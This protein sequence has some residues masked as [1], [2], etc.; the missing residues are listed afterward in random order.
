VPTKELY[1]AAEVG[2]GATGSSPY[3]A[4]SYAG[5]L[6]YSASTPETG[7]ELF[8]YDGTTVELVEDLNPGPGDGIYSSGGVLGVFN[9]KL[10]LKGDDGTT[11][12][13][14]YAFDGNSIELIADVIAGPVGSTF[15]MPDNLIYFDNLLFFQGEAPSVSEGRGYV[16]DFSTE[17]FQ[18]MRDY[19]AGYTK[20]NF[21]D[22]VVFQGDLYFRATEPGQATYIVKYDGTTFSTITAGGYISSLAVWSFGHSTERQPTRLLT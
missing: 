17:T 22:P 14:L 3:S 16:Y 4:V 19:F 21:Y 8:V 13:E 15:Y 20:R 6:Y 12:F 7:R 2:S 1:L 10:F 5:K 9:N 11:G 18:E